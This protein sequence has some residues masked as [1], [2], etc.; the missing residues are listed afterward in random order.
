MP[1]PLLYLDDCL[2]L[3]KGPLLSKAFSNFPR[4]GSLLFTPPAGHAVVFLHKRLVPPPYE[5]CAFPLLLQA[6]M[7]EQ[8]TITFLVT[9]KPKTLLPEQE[10]KSEDT[11][12]LKN[13][14]S[15][16]FLAFPFSL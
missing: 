9:T 8:T 11:N 6:Y 10:E 13:V 4:Q 16:Q 7:T 15:D 14:L 5:G 1:W 12:R 2:A 3:L